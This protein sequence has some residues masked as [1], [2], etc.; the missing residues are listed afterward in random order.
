[1]ERTLTGGKARNALDRARKIRAIT[2]DLAKMH[3]DTSDPLV[4]GA[5]INVIEHL[6][7]CASRLREFTT[8]PETVMISRPSADDLK[9]LN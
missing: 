8:E 5:V 7:D 9:P 4:A 3:A 2:Q 1:M 6:E